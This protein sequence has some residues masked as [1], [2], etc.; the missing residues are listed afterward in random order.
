[1]KFILKLHPEISIKSD[2]V[3]RRFTKILEGNVRNI[4]KAYDFKVAVWNKWDKLILEARTETPEQD[5]Q[6]IDQLKRIP[7]IEQCLQ[8]RQSEYKD[9]HDIYEQVK[10]VWHDK[11]AGK[12]FAVRVKRRGEH[13]FTSMDVAR[14][15]G[16]GLNQHCVSGGVE[17]KRPDVQIELEIDKDQLLLIDHRFRCLGGMPLP[18]QED[19]LSLISGGFDSGVASY[20][21][22]RRGARTH[23][24]FFNL[25]GRQHEIGVKQASYYLWK[26]YSASHKVKFIAV[27]FEPVVA[28]ILERVDNGLMGV[29]LKRM[30]LRA[31]SM[32]A[33]NLAI[34]T[35]VTG[36]CLGQVSSQTLTNLHVI[37]QTTD[38]LVLRPIVCMDKSEIISIARQIG[39]EDFAKSMPEYCGV[40]SKKPTVHAILEQVQEQEAKLDEDLITKVVRAS[41]VLDIRRI[42]EDTEKEV[43]QVEAVEAMPEG[44]V[45]LDIRAPEEE[46]NKPLSVPDH[47]VLHIPFFQLAR[48][49]ADLDQSRAYF[50]YC[51][52]GVMSNMQALLLHEQGYQNVKVYRP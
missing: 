22:I 48:K 5:A 6:V 47:Q 1:M 15:V 17:L 16:G 33:D 14:Y 3:R 39:T 9:L 20:Q 49:F 51:E 32:V 25:G 10:A 23:Y 42:A 4:F 2:S 29:V 40:I 35:L 27:D 43:A 28:Q 45:V 30:M 26:R 36:E 13:D 38:K 21:M 31:A 44:A 52:R 46:E 18:T 12:T 19:V 41:N 24:C 37:T 7:G 11:L 50:L 8:V 34:T